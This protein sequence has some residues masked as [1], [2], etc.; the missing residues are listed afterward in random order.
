[1]VKDYTVYPDWLNSLL[2]VPCLEINEHTKGHS[3]SPWA[4]KN[5][6]NFSFEWSRTVI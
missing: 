3:Y 2:N 4:Q 5:V 1:M 6:H